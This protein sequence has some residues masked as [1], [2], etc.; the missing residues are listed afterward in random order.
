MSRSS[1]GID[2]DLYDYLVSHGVR[3]PPLLQRLRVETESHSRASMQ[4]SAEQGAFMAMLVRLTGARRCL[5]IGVF[6]GYS[7]LA[8]ALALPED[9]RLI[10]C[11]VSEEWTNVAR[12]YWREAGVEQKVDLRLA[13]AIDT[14]DALLA[15]G[16]A[17]SFD[18]AFIDADKEGYEAYYERALELM[19]VGGLILVDNVL[20]KGLVIDADNQDGSTKAL[21]EFNQRRVSDERVELVMLPVGDGLSLLRKR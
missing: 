18:F 21:R 20:W 5:E 16:A 19:R 8:V 1:I 2:G 12:Q 4:I 7:S 10:A 14:L 11:D 9:G 6:T 3:E 17:G 15:S 13:P